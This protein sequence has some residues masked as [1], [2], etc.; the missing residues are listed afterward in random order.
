MTCR[1]RVD[2]PFCN[3]VHH[4]NKR[5]WRVHEVKMDEV[6]DSQLLEL[7]HNGAQVGAQDLGVRVLLHLVLVRFLRVQPETTH[8]FEPLDHLPMTL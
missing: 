4:E 5:T 2:R 8:C 3:P 7:Q 1:A 6:V